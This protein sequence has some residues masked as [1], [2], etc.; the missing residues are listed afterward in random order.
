M[1][2]VNL[3]RPNGDVVTVDEARAERLRRMGYRD[4]DTGERM[5]LADENAEREMYSG[6]GDQVAAGLEGVASG[7]TFGASDALLD[8]AGAD[9]AKRAQYNPGTRIAGE[10]VGAIGVPLGALGAGRLANLAARTPAGALARST[11]RLS[12]KIG[13]VKG[14][15]VG[16]GIEGAVVGAG[17]EITAATLSGDPLTVEGVLAHAGLGSVFGA[18]A[19]LLAH[20]IGRVAE[21]AGHVAAPVDDVI[22]KAP[23]ARPALTATEAKAL[24]REA[25]F[26]DEAFGR[27]R[28]AVDDFRKA[29]DDV[30]KQADN[31]V[32]AATSPMA[33]RSLK[34]QFQSLK[35]AGDE[36][37]GVATLGGTASAAKVE[38]SGARKAW[39]RAKKAIDKGDDEATKLALG[40]Y[41]AA[42]TRLN[43]AT[44][45][46]SKIPRL[47]VDVTEESVSRSVSAA[48]EALDV[49]SI[50]DAAKR[51]PRSA[52]EFFAMKP[53][54]AEE[55]FAAIEKAMSTG[56]PE[57]DVIKGALVQQVDEV[58]TRAG[59][60]STGNPADKLRSVYGLHKKVGADAVTNRAK[61]KL[62]A[63]EAPIKETKAETET[64]GWGP[65]K[66]AKRVLRQ[67][68]ARTG[69]SAAHKAGAGVLGGSLAYQSAG[70]AAGMMLGGDAGGPWGLVAAAELTGARAAAM[71]RIRGAVARY[72]AKAATGTRAIGARV[73]P[74]SYSLMNRDDD[75]SEGRKALFARRSAELRELGAVGKDRA[76]ALSAALTEAGHGDFAVATHQQVSKAL[77]HLL[78]AL[79]RDPGATPWALGSLWKP[80]AS[81]MDLYS[82]IH[83][84]VVRPL[85]SIEA[86]LGGDVHPAEAKAL[87]EVW[88]ELH[89]QA[90]VEI[91]HRLSDPEFVKGLRRQQ[92]TGLS[93]FADIPLIPTQRP[94]FI[95]AQQQMWA[96][97][98]PQPSPSGGGGG[99]GGRPPGPA[100]EPPTPT[101]MLLNR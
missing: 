83:R 56:G 31:A 42:L 18:G 93:V 67:A 94:E 74:L 90:K 48:E 4:E 36:I 82:R 28:G 80:T 50:H 8:A 55:M 77:D 9:T 92:L 15:V 13:G 5:A 47:A 64:K 97:R 84:A 78:A 27:L 91:I 69:S 16:A 21:K 33:V 99:G 1:G 32:A 81:Q 3:V 25:T 6:L 34:Q 49:R 7:I 66:F 86:M 26:P 62:A 100:M 95:S 29:A 51:F 19:G 58:L 35:Y 2:K 71:G 12:Q 87:R 39:S 57:M 70:L 85:D 44:G 89:S 37:A 54:K 63:D 61:A 23:K 17:S 40:E 11:T 52:D 24:F 59:V 41:H 46:G 88:P 68:A 76:Y 98:A 79:P 60:T 30:M 65:W 73:E 43:A 101:Q 96:E 22:L 14:A 75:P 20:G 53:G 38:M 45:A 72:G 10:L